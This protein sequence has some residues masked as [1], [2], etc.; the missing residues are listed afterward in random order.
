MSTKIRP[1]AVAGTFYP[2]DR[3][4]LESLL[5]SC[6]ETDSVPKSRGKI[7]ALVSPHAGIIYSGKV[8]GEGYRLLKNLNINNV[9][10]LAPSHYEYFEG[11]TVYDGSAYSTPLGD[12]TINS[13]LSSELVAATEQL[14]YSSVGHGREHSLEVQLPF[15]QTVLNND[16]EIVP[17]V[18]GDIDMA[19]AS[20]IASALSDSVNSLDSDVLI[21]ASTDLSHFHKQDEA[22]LLDK[23][24][25]GFIENL[26][27]SEL[28]TACKSGEC[29][30][31]GV[32]PLLIVMEAAKLQGALDVE[33]LKYATSGDVI[34]DYSSVVGYLSAVI[35]GR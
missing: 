35:T 5:G 25:A 24:T 15:L 13:E 34:G 8:A 10:I 23:R 4:E 3:S 29:E 6:F 7:F 2:A 26:S 31:C 20:E 9:I 33:I 30:A 11:G 27:I 21:I 14:N 18:I 28:Y 22:N 12:I 32:N 16:F 17:I 19:K 1:A